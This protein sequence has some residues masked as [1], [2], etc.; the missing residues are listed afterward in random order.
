MIHLK[1][2]CD[3][4]AN[5]V[6]KEVIENVKS[7]PKTFNS[8]PLRI[9]NNKIVIHPH[10]YVLNLPDDIPYNLKSRDL[11]FHLKVIEYNNETTLIL[12]EQFLDELSDVDLDTVASLGVDDIIAVWDN[13]VIR[14]AIL[15]DNFTDLLTA[16]TMMLAFCNLFMND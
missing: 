13:N 1:H 4:K 2:V 8:E 6:L 14:A 5:V 9:E 11:E 10:Y 15:I 16:R 12:V 3:Q 7:L